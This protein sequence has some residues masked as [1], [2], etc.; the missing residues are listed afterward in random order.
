VRAELAVAEDERLVLVTPGG[1]EDGYAMIDA[2]VR[3]L[4]ECPAEAKL[5][6]LI[7]HGPEIPEE[8]QAMLRARVE[9]NSSVILRSFT[10]D[11]GSYMGAADLVV[12]MGGYNT[13]CEVLSLKKRAI[14]VPRVRPVEEQL[15]RAE[16]LQRLGLL[17]MLHPDRLTPSGMM[18]AVLA[19]LAKTGTWKSADLDF[20]ALPRVAARVRNLLPSKPAPCV[21]RSL[22]IDSFAAF[23]AA[24]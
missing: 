22:S 13:V 4:A 19:E 16:R 5:K 9:G 6:T 24:R 3:G 1:G 14:L 18:R 12:S 20:D 21:H 11:I 17:T 2:Y 10:G 23:A 15:I 8:H 7:V